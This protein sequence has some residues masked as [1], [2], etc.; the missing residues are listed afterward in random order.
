[1][2]PKCGRHVW[3]IKSS[4]GSGS[5][6]GAN[7]A[8]EKA[9][10]EQ[11]PASWQNRWNACAQEGSGWE[12]LDAKVLSPSGALYPMGTRENPPELDWK[13]KALSKREM[14][15]KLS[16]SIP[17]LVLF[18]K[19]EHKEFDAS[20]QEPNQVATGLAHLCPESPYEDPKVQHAFEHLGLLFIR[21][22][23]GF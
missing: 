15:L 4:S 1:M 8:G 12:G 5:W 17:C 19:G 16:V 21:L 6:N 14:V 7:W 20:D 23:T 2:A 11:T 18:F 22:F 10:Q 13:K 9:E 3:L